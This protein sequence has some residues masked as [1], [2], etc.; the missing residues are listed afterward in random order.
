MQHLGE[1]GVDTG[2]GEKEQHIKSSTRVKSQMS[3]VSCVSLTRVSNM[4]E[5]F[6]PRD[7]PAFQND[8]NYKEVPSASNSERSPNGQSKGAERHESFDFETPKE[9]A[10]TK[11][12]PVTNANPEIRSRTKKMS[13]GVSAIVKAKQFAQQVAEKHRKGSDIHMIDKL[14]RYVFPL[15]FFV[16]N[17]IYFAIVLTL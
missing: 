6:E 9:A 14:C 5:N 15:T 11:D 2:L 13:V 12:T 3:F 8:S 1:N 17:A 4:S 16:F 7:N 10:Y